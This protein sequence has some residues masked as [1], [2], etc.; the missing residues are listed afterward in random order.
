[1]SYTRFEGPRLERVAEPP[2]LTLKARAVQQLTG[3]ATYRRKRE[4]W[5]AKR[6]GPAQRL[7]K[8]GNEIHGV[9]GRIVETGRSPVSAIAR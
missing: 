6:V 3:T 4:L 7:V 2:A 8:L 9:G 5:P 1:M